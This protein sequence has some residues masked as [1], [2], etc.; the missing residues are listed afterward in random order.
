MA[1]VVR[2]VEGTHEDVV[3]RAA[4]EAEET[5]RHVIAA[6]LYVVMVVCAIR[7]TWLLLAMFGRAGKSVWYYWT[8][9]RHIER[10]KKR[11]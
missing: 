7:A 2:I 11:E 3:R 10:G 5:S 4:Q 9:R 1:K 8:E 6:V